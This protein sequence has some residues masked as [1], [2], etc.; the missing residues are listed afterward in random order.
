MIEHTCRMHRTRVTRILCKSETPPKIDT[1]FRPGDTDRRGHERMDHVELQRQA[2]RGQ[3][4]EPLFTGM[5][6]RR[7][8]RRTTPADL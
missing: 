5:V 1:R 2:G 6:D 8:F 3:D 7:R 4:G